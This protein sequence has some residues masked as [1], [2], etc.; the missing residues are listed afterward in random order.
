MSSI[1][2][3]RGHQYHFFRRQE[4]RSRWDLASATQFL[5]QFRK[6]GSALALLRRQV[7]S[8][9]AL[10]GQGALTDDQVI[11][12]L[13]R[14]LVSGDLVVVPPERGQLLATQGAEAVAETQAPPP[15]PRTAPEPEEEPPT[16]DGDHDG[17]TQAAVLI[18]AAREAFPFCEECQ[19]AYVEQHQVQEAGAR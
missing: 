18:A 9:P 5:N 7:L 11:A 1:R 12:A 6:D 15:P 2:Y 3:G 14:M 17:V 4:I 16:F 13:A 8:S 10:G 19:K